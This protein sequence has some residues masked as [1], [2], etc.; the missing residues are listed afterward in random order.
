[1][2][3]V[4]V[5]KWRLRLCCVSWKKEQNVQEE[6]M[7]RLKI[8]T[9]NLTKASLSMIFTCGPLYQCINNTT[10]LLLYEALD[11]SLL[12]DRSFFLQF[13]IGFFVSSSV[14]SW[15]GKED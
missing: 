6:Q 3:R 1:M 14:D 11:P 10:H 9:K 7:H 12:K 2:K 4:N 13:I 8:N 15:R 5:R